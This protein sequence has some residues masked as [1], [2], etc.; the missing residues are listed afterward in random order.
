MLQKASFYDSSP[1]E[2]LPFQV[3]GLLFIYFADRRAVCRQACSEELPLSVKA[4]R[5][6]IGIHRRPVAAGSTRFTP[7]AN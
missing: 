4:L 7:T 3:F 6:A 1:K 2:T 5:P